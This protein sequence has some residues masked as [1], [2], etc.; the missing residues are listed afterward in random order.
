MSNS[1]ESPQGPA[2]FLEQS[3]IDEAILA[4]RSSARRRMIAP[5]QRSESALVQRMLNVMQPGSYVRPHRHPRPQ[6]VELIQVLQGALAVFVFSENGE[7][8]TART[9][10]PGVSG[11]LLDLEPGVWH[12]F[13]PLSPDT[14][15]LEIKGGPYDAKLDK[16]WPDWAPEEGADAA[17]AYAQSLLEQLAIA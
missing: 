13:L 10:R 7:V 12:T 15:V 8:L 3:R 16:V 14:V 11:S 2:Y 9:L 4:S 5:I 17:E 6:S 1:L